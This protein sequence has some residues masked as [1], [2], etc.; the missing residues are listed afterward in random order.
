MA[1]VCY[2][3]GAEFIDDGVAAD[4]CRRQLEDLW[5]RP[6][7]TKIYSGGEMS[8]AA[9]VVEEN[10]NCMGSRVFDDLI[11][12]SYIGNGYDENMNL[13]FAKECASSLSR[14]TGVAYEATLAEKRFPWADAYRV[15]TR[16]SFWTSVEQMVR[17]LIS[18]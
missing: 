16:D 13:F 2:G 1:G 7:V 12:D 8:G 3:V 14:M 5:H 10:P 9:Y 6:L 17:N 15:T 11:V 4:K 18:R